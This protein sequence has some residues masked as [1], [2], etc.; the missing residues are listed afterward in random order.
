M[1]GDMRIGILGTGVVGRAFGRALGDL[2]HEVIIGTRDPE[3]TRARDEWLNSPL[4]LARYADMHADLWI[5][6]TSGR[7]ALPAVQ[8]VGPAL[9]GKVVIDTSNPLDFSHGF[10]PTL[11][12]S[13]TDSLAEQLQRGVPAA[14]IVKMFSTTANEVM[15]DPR[16]LGRDST[17]FVAGDDPAARIVAAALARELGW[18]DVLDLGDLTAARGLEMWMPLWL[19]LYGAIGRADFNIKVIR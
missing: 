16:A 5:N 8:A 11:F 12:V 15:V 9:D 14:R 3:A 6:A 13:N 7:G 4:T 18:S 19:R 17:L 1:M 2:G 10:P